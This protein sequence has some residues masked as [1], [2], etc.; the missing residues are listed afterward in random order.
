MRDRFGIF[1]TVI[2]TRKLSLLLVMTLRMPNNDVEFDET[3]GS[4]EEDDNLDDVRGTQL[5]DAM[6]NMDIGD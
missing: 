3:N 5:A 4:Q 1:G 6:K 2:R